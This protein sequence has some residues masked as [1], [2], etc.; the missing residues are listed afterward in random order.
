MFTKESGFSILICIPKNNLREE[1]NWPQVPLGKTNISQILSNMKILIDKLRNLDLPQP[2]SAKL[3][4]I[5]V[6]K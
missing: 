6:I 4:I 3:S 5:K 1:L 2:I